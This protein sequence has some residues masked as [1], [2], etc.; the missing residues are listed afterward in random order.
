MHLCT[1]TV[2]QFCNSLCNHEQ[3]MSLTSKPHRPTSSLSLK[4][5]LHIKSVWEWQHY[6]SGLDVKL[7]KDTEISLRILGGN[8][9][10]R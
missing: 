1:T 6:T 8:L 10:A 4:R 5:K 3:V 7:F 9:A 2:P